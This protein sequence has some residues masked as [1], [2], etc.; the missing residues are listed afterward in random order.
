MTHTCASSFLIRV[1]LFAF[2]VG[3]VAALRGSFSLSRLD[4]IGHLVLLASVS[5]IDES[6]DLLVL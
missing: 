3:L 4:C 2:R 1:C 6:A 5:C